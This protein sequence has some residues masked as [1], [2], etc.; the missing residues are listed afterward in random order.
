MKRVDYLDFIEHEVVRPLPVFFFCAVGRYMI[1][2]LTV[3]RCLLLPPSLVHCRSWLWTMHAFTMEKRS[4]NWLS[5]FASVLN[6]CLLT[7]QT[8]TQSKRCFR[9]SRPSSVVIRIS[10]PHPRVPALSST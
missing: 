3:D 6:S 1:S 9:K 5:A 10:S 2:H 8:S 7:P 4:W